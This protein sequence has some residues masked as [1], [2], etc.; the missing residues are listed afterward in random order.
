MSKSAL[1]YIKFQG[2]KLPA[3]NRKSYIHLKHTK[4]MANQENS[5]FLSILER[6]RGI[7]K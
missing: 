2:P 6:N 4:T 1:E 7:H 5:L 3:W